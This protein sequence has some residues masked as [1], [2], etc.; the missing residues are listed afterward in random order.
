MTELVSVVITTYMRPKEVLFRAIDSVQKQTYQNIEIIVVD[1]SPSDYIV[2]NELKKWIEENYKDKITLIQHDTNM[3]AC[4]ARN[5]GLSASK[6]CYIAFLDDDDEWLPEKI[7]QQLPQLRDEDVALVYCGKMVV[8][9][10]TGKI[11]QD[12]LVVHT[13][14]VYDK[15]MFNNFIG[16][17]SFP[18]LR[19]S[20]VL[21][22]GG[23]D[24]LMRSAQDY[25]MWLRLA[26][27][28]KIDCVNRAL[29]KYHV[30]DGERISTNHQARISGQERLIQK[31]KDYLIQNPKAEWWRLLRLSI[32]YGKSKQLMKALKIWTKSCI[33]QPFRI[34]VNMDYLIHIIYYRF[35][36]KN[37]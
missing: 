30:H 25:D 17:T 36:R 21:E 31:N 18:L 32:Q 9:D 22:V 6:G 11:S 7:E 20:A 14:Y 3:G 37:K 1:D 28:Y 4:V 24:P 5:T 2:R 12:P 35:T 8:N 29:V 16:S 19:R 13:G 15:L 27:K 34:V 23:F 33:K 10:S 26:K